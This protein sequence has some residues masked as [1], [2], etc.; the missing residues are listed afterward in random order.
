MLELYHWEPNANSGRSLL[1]MKEKGLEFTSRYVDLL[2]F[3]QLDADFAKSNPRTE[4]PVLVH[5]GQVYTE[6]TCIEQYVDEVYPSPGLMPRD[7]F[8]RWRVRAWQKHVDEEIAPFVAQLDAPELR[9]RLSKRYD[10]A[11]LGDIVAGIPSKERRDV[12]AAAVL[13]GYTDEQLAEGRRKI[14]AFVAGEVE[15]ALART[16]WLAGEA[17]TLADCAAFCFVNLLPRLAPDI[18]NAQVTP[19]THAWLKRMSAR[20]AVREM[21]KMSRTGDPFGCTAPGPEPIRWG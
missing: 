16:A 1:L 21:V 6:T 2:A 5:G 18:V 15:P 20:P 11:Q 19:A 12:W 10:A 13:T 4:V 3:E 14:A 9:Q 7:A 8:G 17:Y